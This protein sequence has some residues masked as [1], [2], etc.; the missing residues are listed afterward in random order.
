MQRLW[1]NIKGQIEELFLPPGAEEV[2]PG[3]IWGPPDELFT[4]SFWKY[5]SEAQIYRNRYSSHR[6]GDTLLEEIAVCLLGG[7]GIPAEMGLAAF[8]RLRD[9]EV[10]QGTA[11]ETQMLQLLSQ[12]FNMA[13]KVRRYRFAA[14]KARYLSR[15]LGM[16]TNLDSDLPARELRDKLLAFQGIGPKTASWIVRNYLNSD[17][18]AIIDVH[19]HRACVMMKVFDP[20]ANP[21]RDYFK[22][23]DSFLRFAQAIE[24]RASV[25]DAVMWDIMRRIGPTARA[26]KVNSL[27]DQLQLDF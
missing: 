19:L 22:L 23:E 7:Y 24:V 20:G 6:L 9:H 15:A 11:T 1:I 14:Q 10:L 21:T 27:A 17:D 26:V 2:M 16:A 12:P 13:G 3:V 8:E 18:V 25:L 5:Q 4:P